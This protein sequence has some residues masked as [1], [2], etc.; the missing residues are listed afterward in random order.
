[1]TQLAGVNQCYGLLSISRR[2]PL[3]PVIYNPPQPIFIIH[4]EAKKICALANIRPIAFSLAS[5][6]PPL[7]TR[8]TTMGKEKHGTKEGKKPA[9]LTHKEKKVAKQVKKQE[10]AAPHPLIPR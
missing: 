5:T 7:T 8:R 3:A 9:V 10:K 6:C 2:L 4:D 1:M